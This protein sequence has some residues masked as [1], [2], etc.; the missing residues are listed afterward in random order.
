MEGTVG[1]RARRGRPG[2]HPPH[3]RLLCALD[4]FETRGIP[5]IVAVNCFDDAEV[6]DEDEVRHAL[7]VDP[8]VPVQFCDA[9]QR[10][11]GKQVLLRLLEYLSGRGDCK[12]VALRRSAS[13][14]RTPLVLARSSA[15]LR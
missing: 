12:S 6:Y 2:R 11:S 5:F 9:R 10:D 7:D 3:R 14:S 13:I 8:G 15:P 4:F 1:G